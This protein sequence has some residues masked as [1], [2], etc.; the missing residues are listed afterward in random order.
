MGENIFHGLVIIITFRIFYLLADKRNRNG[1]VYGVLGVFSFYLGLFIGGWVGVFVLMLLKMSAPQDLI[2]IAVIG[3]PIAV[4]VCWGFY[5]F[6]KRK[7]AGD[8]KIS[9]PNI[10]DTEQLSDK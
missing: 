9:D 5:V 4:L 3:L 10:L 7:W 1:W 2:Y 8:I 6:L